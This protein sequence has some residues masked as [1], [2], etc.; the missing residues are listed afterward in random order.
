M[1]TN[2]LITRREVL[3]GGLTSVGG[4]ILTGCSK[5]LPPT[6]GNILRTGDVLTYSAQRALLPGRKLAREYS[7]KDISSFPAIGTTD[8]G[9]PALPKSSEIYRRLQN[10]GFADCKLSVEGLVAR[11]GSFSLADLKRFPSRTQITKHTCEEGWSAIGEWTGVPLSTVLDAAGLLPNA[12]FVSFYTYDDWAD[13]IDLLDAL[14]PQTILAYGMNGR[15]LTVA[16]GA[17]VRLR[18]ETQLGYKSMKYLQR[19]VVTEEL[20]DGG[21]KGNIQNGWSWYAGI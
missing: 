20:D 8:P 3:L 12:R 5:A 14:H 9:D 17:P 6:Y 11:P 10:G 18:V 2:K 16:H 4:L 15:E 13:S 19:I 21:E 7:H 1:K